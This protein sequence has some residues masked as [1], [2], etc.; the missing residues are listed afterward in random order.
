MK[1]VRVP[2]SSPYLDSTNL[3]CCGDHRLTCHNGRKDGKHQTWVESSG[4]HGI[5]KGIGIGLRFIADVGGLSNVLMI[6]STFRPSFA[7]TRET[8]C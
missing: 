7:R 3:K 1:L 6:I 5:V 8:H 2:T 4:W